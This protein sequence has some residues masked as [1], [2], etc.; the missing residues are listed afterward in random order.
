MKEVHP[1]SAGLAGG[2]LWEVEFCRWVLELE[3]PDWAEAVVIYHHSR[4]PQWWD[5]ELELGGG[6]VI[7]GS[8]LGQVGG[9]V[10]H[11]VGPGKLA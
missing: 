3:R 7:T 4:I 6:G 1:G 11:P 9:R 5:T 10:R 8:A 2:G